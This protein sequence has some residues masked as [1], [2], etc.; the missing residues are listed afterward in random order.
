LWFADKVWPLVRTQR[1]D[2]KFLVIGATPTAAIRR[3]ASAE[4]GIEVTG[5][6]PEVT[7]HLAKCAVAVAPIHVARGLQNKV[8]ESLSLG[9]PTVVTSA[10]AE[11]LPAVTL[12]GCRV[13]DEAGA[14][15]RHVVELLALTP[16]ERRELAACANLDTLTWP[17]QLSQLPSI[18]A[19][20]KYASV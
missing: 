19:G 8:L 18:L 20:A 10:V 6:V 15:A 16:D 2:A 5:S 4:S 13:A 12:T 3:L 7:P 14:F 1:P 17:H 9:L 11:G